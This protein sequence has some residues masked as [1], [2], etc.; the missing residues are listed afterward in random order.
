MSSGR[1]TLGRLAGGTA[2]DIIARHTSPAGDMQTRR[3]IVS[4][5]LALAVAGCGTVTSD[6]PDDAGDTGAHADAG[7][8]DDTLVDPANC[9]SCGRRCADLPGV[10]GDRVTCSAGECQVAAACRAG[11]GDCDELEETGCEADLTD[12]ATCG[13]CDVA[14]SGTD[15]L[16]GA[17]ADSWA[18]RAA[19]SETEMECSGTCA[20]VAEDAAHCGRCEHACGGGDCVAGQCQ[21]VAVATGRTD[22]VDLAVTAD[23]IY[24]SETGSG[25][26]DG[27]IATCPLP[28][29]TLAP[30]FITD[31]RGRVGVLA[32]AGSD[33]Y[34][35]G[36]SGDSCDDQHRLYQCPVSGCP[37]VPPIQASHPVGWV[38][39][40]IGPTHVYAL[41]STDLVGCLRADCAGTDVRWSDTLFGGALLGVALGEES[42]Y[43]DGGAELR[44]CPE[45]EGCAAPAVVAGSIGVDSP[46][47]AHAGRLYWFAPFSAGVVHVMTCEAASCS[48]SLFATESPGVSELEVDDTGV[49]WLNASEGWIRQCPLTGCVGAPA[50]LATRLTAPKALALGEG[51]VYWIEGSDI[52]RVAKP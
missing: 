10:D 36:C 24:W 48:P 34:F 44:S 15:P 49:Y 7:T 43:V 6:E 22:P 41:A 23:A 2:G 8:C 31:A 45:A 33:I 27:K 29:C 12:P 35:A 26:M 14:C 20:D 32:V 30:R 13:S 28:G 38:A 11:L 3:F 19:C 16:C 9:G 1:A 18:C 39:L 17:M 46:F 40:A 42:L 21:P 51:F 37:A 52:R 4:S 50:Y 47:R 5:A 25:L